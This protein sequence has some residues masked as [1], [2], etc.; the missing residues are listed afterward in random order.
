MNKLLKVIVVVAL[1][2]VVGVAVGIAY[3]YVYLPSYYQQQSVSYYNQQLGMMG[4]FKSGGPGAM[5]GMM[6]GMMG[7]GPGF[8]MMGYYHGYALAYTG[9]VSVSQA[10]AEVNA[11]GEAKVFR[12]NDTIVF[13]STDISI[14]VLSM[15]HVRALNL[16]HYVPP[17][18]AHYQHN[19]FVVMGLINPTIIAPSGAT[20][21]VVFINLD[22]GD[23]HN[24]AIT[25]V[26][27]PYPYYAM[28][29]V[30]MDV[31]AV[32][33]MIPPANYASGYAYE[34]SF[35]VTL[36]SPGVYYYLCEYPGHAQMGM[37]GEIVVV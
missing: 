32:T 18:S 22:A 21:H 16:T 17:Q 14:V 23:Y 9:Q 5:G 35:T 12:S 26:P 30:K 36:S 11:T 25:P 2:A 24:L 13:T 33:P 7:Y 27:P 19:V 3:T 20:L 37:Y 8:E 10:E 28:M 6:G 15:G 4:Y 29:Y 34:F 1:V 31:F